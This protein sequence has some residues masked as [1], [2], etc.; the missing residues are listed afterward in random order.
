AGIDCCRIGEVSAITQDDIE[1][2]ATVNA[3]LRQTEASYASD[4]A[5][6]RVMTGSLRFLLADGNLARAWRLSSIGGPMTFKTNCI[7]STRSGNVVALCGGGDLLPGIPFSACRGASLEVKTLDLAS[8]CR[9]TRIQ[10]DDTK[11]STTELIQY[12]ANARG[13]SHYDP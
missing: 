2:I 5:T 13:G 6:L 7:T 4:E 11:I 9:S 3:H 10:I 12:V 8:F 1:L